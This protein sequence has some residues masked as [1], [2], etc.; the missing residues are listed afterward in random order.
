MVVGMV[1]YFNAKGDNAQ[2]WVIISEITGGKKEFSRNS[3][4]S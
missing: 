4:F 2:Y 1:I 3:D